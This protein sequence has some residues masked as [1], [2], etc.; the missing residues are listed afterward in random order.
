MDFSKL[1][2]LSGIAARLDFLAARTTVIAQNIAHSDTP[3]YVAKDLKKPE[4]RALARM[5]AMRVSDPRHIAAASASGS[6]FKVEAA[7]DGEASLAGNQV[8]LET[9]AMKLSSTR[10]EYALAASLYRKGL[11]MLRLAARGQ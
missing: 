5:E 1:P 3:D 7:P 11:A 6:G 8:S 10:Q 2:L 4:F 9:Q